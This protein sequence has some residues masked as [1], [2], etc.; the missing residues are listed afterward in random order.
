VVRIGITELSSR[1][2]VDRSTIWR[3][4]RS[5]KFPLPHYLGE[6]RTWFLAEVE[7]WER[8]RMAPLAEPRRTSRNAERLNRARK[9]P[10][11]P[12]KE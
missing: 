1:L 4:Y 3:W 5:G 7:A 2:G 8:D 10:P 9:Q 12:T 11:A 6:R